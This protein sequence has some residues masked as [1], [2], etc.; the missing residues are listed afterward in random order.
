MMMML[1]TEA[2][3][4]CHSGRVTKGRSFEELDSKGRFQRLGSG[5]KL[6]SPG[7]AF[8]VARLSSQMDDS[9]PSQTGCS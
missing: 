6:A 2:N 1:V 9:H 3:W 7:P 8:S 5:P 4:D